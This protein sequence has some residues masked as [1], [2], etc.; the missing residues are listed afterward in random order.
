MATIVAKMLEVEAVRW[1][2]R[3]IDGEVPQWIRT[4]LAKPTP[5]TVGGIMRMHDEIHVGTR[6]GILHAR[7]GDWIVR[8]GEDDLIALPDVVVHALFE[9]PEPPVQESGRFGHHPDPATDFCVEV[10]AIEGYHYDA[11]RGLS[12]PGEPPR[13]IDPAFRVRVNAAMDFVVGGDPVAV[14]AKAILRQIYKEVEA[15]FAELPSGEGATA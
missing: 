6:Q 13:Q 11:Q 2:G 15:V 9:M 12:K 5:E 8:L 3:K 10:E 1:N 7:P 14:R 4:G